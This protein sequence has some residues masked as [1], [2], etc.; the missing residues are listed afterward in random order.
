MSR[1]LEY[2]RRKLEDKA[3]K[4]RADRKRDRRLDARTDRWLKAHDGGR[5][6]RG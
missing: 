4:T 2:E 1:P 6:N 5:R 3:R